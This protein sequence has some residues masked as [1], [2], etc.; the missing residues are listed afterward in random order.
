MFARLPSQSPAP[1]GCASWAQDP[2]I[3]AFVDAVQYPGQLRGVGAAAKQTL[4]SAAEFRG[5]DLPG[6]G[7]AD[8]GQMRSVD[9]AALEERQFVVEFEAVD[10]KGILRRTDPAQRLLREQAL[11]GQVVDGQNGGDLDCVPG[12]VGRHQRSLPVIGV[13]QIRCPI[14]VQSACRELGRGGGKSPEADV[15]VRPVTAG[16]V[17]I[18]I[19]GAVVELRAQQ[20]VNRQAILGRLPARASRPA[21]PPM[22]AH[23]PTIWIWVN[24]STTSR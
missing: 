4:E 11:I 7:L 15:I 6:I 24:C 22:P 1:N 5:G 3:P 17:A 10:M 16:G 19:A 18:G 8:G 21:F 20:D 9:D 13:N 23:W 2:R 12:E 14:F